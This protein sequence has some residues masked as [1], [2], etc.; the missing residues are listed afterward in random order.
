MSENRENVLAKS[1]V[2][3]AYEI[4]S[5]LGPG[6]YESVY[7]R[8]LSC[9][10]ELRGLSVARQVEIPVEWKG[11]SIDHAFRADLIVENK[12]ILELKSCDKLEAIYHKQLLTY[13]KLTG[14]R[15]G[16]LINFNER[17]I[18]RGVKRIVNNLPD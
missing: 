18:G 13:L 4:H 7:E 17:N 11:I 8:I 14:Y 1:V 2:Q 15:L 9:E 12:L 5:E 6:L 16:L 3:T 10:L